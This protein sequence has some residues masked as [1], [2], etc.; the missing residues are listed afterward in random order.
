MSEKLEVQYKDGKIFAPLRNKWLVTKPEE[1]VRQNYIV[2]LHNNYGYSLEQMEQELKVSNAKR[3]QGKARAD[4]VIW[5]NPEEKR[6]RK[7]AFIVVEC[8]AENVKVQKEDYFQGL[9]Y[10]SWAKAQFLVCTNEKE[11]K[12]FSVNQEKI[13]D[14]LDEIVEI[15]Q[16]E[17]VNNEKR[18][19]EILAQLKKFTRDEFQKVLF[20]CHNVIR[21]NDKLSPEMAFDEI[22]KILFMKI[23]YERD[24]NKGGLFSKE[25]FEQ[26]RKAY[27][28]TDSTGVPFYQHFFTNTKTHFKADD[29]FENNDV[30]RIK[31]I[32]FLQIVKLL[33]KYNLSD[34]SDDVKGIAFEEFLGKTFRGDLGQFFT[35]R[36]IVD[37]MVQ[38]LDPQECE[39]VCDP[40]CGTGGFLI[41]TF[42][43]VRERI[44][45][46]IQKEKEKVKK[47]LMSNGFSKLT[48]KEQDKI[49]Q[50]LNEAWAKLNWDL[51]TRNDKS[52]LFNLSFNRIYGT[53]AE[54]RSARTAKMNMIMHGDGHG[55]VHHHDGLLN[56][57]GIFENRFDVI[58][59]NPPFG[60][61]I[62]KE[63]K[64]TETD[65]FTDEEKISRYKSRFGDDYINALKQ[66]NDN[67][68]KNILGLFDLG[69]NSTLTEVIFLER[70]LKLLKKGGR[71]GIVLPEGFLNNSDLQK[72][73][74]YFEGRAKI[75]LIVSIPQDVFI[76]AGAT[77]KPSLV[78]LKKYTEKEEK[79]YI[80]ILEEATRETELKYKPQIEGLNNEVNQLQ[81]QLEDQKKALKE[82]R[83][84]KKPKKQID[85]STKEIKALQKQITEK[86]KEV[87][88]KLSEIEQIK[89]SEIKSIVKERFD[90]EVP[91]AQIEKAGITSTG[92]V[93]E[94]E[95]LDLLKE[96]TV[97]RTKEKPWEIPSKPVKYHIDKS[98]VTRIVV[99]EKKV[100]YAN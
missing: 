19:K 81:S 8:K 29:L 33:E 9:N 86:K 72:V 56:I 21:N 97:Y 63:L 30:L 62:S 45:K 70:C 67:I 4:I 11:T 15:P 71:L 54:P 94:N 88:K 3:G 69:K 50:D 59:T 78:F 31:E 10:A 28:E 51:D 98:D 42:E 57:N 47:K 38:V 61:R 24:K 39:I 34:T 60:A 5:K 64:I 26:L 84:E 91:V 48:E 32:S 65:K 20:E 92:A 22:S 13:P 73:R 37:F 66:V 76:A 41:K 90:Y 100:E 27:Q 7:K 52:R 14:E 16:A 87:K 77:V 58:L 89:A 6:E 99:A 82:I 75:L 36:T 55:G 93:C 80:R 2:N 25:R 79:E 1:V 23:F 83:K 18:V 35:P 49:L 43:H 95:L 68:N 53:D 74:D 44:E 46:E 40:C 17:E 12:F 85:T 96:F